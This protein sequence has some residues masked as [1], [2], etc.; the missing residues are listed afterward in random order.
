M[1]RQCGRRSAA[2]FSGLGSHILYVHLK[3]SQVLLSPDSAKSVD[4]PNVGATVYKYY[5]HVKYLQI[6]RHNGI[7]M[8][9]L[10]TILILLT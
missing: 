7:I 6:Y 1:R 8:Q 5:I 4:Q 9:L 10:I 3:H 2:K